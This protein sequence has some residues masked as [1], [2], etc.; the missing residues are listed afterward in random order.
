MKPST[1]RYFLA[2]GFSNLKKNM[3]MTVASIVAVAACISILSFSYCVGSNLKH[4][5]NQMEDSIGISVF[6][7]GELTGTEIEQMKNN[8]G[9]IEH[10]E[11]VRYISPNDA[12]ET[13][14][15]DWGAEEDIFEGL[16]SENNPL[17]H[18]FQISMEG[19]KYQADILKALESVEGIDNVRHGQ[20]ETEVLM[21]ANR[22][23]NI[24]SALIMLVLGVI[25]VMII[26]NTIRIS[27]VN[28]RV[29]INIMKYVGA[30][31]WFIRWPFVIEG[32]MIGMIG[33]V[34][35]LLL[36]FPIYAKVT[37]MIFEYLPM[38]NFIQ[39]RLAGD[40]FAVLIPFGILFGIALG[41]I[42]SITSIRKH[43][44]V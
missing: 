19:I 25:S 13:L 29:E 32:V 12:L 42:G 16:D 7:S 37:G 23:F 39:F 1:I 43:L 20:T 8:I 38:I 21:K 17:S 30:T 9:M 22:I 5:L 31:D 24:S 15:Q 4:M 10:V 44:R 40:I 33:A 14:K 11:D 6:L 36:G 26:M 28:R 41:V 34:I 35:P 2:E 27:V 18:S 3:L